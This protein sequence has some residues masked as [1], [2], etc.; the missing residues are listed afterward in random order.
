MT[1]TEIKEKVNAFLVEEFEMAADALTETADLRQDLGIDS[2]DFV[3]IIAIVNRTFG[4]KPEAAE[5]KQVRT[6][7]DFYT[8]IGQK[9]NA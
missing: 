3:D 5:M 1:N 9:V 2:L 8:Y 7:G 4:F 6:L